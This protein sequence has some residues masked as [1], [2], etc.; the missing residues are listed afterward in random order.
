M[1]CSTGRAA[2]GATSASGSF[3][4][5]LAPSWLDPRIIAR[6]MMRLASVVSES[7]PISWS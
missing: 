6:P 5:T 3:S 2:L 4:Q 7:W 1:V